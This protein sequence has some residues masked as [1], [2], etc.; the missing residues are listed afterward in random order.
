MAHVATRYPDFTDPIQNN[1]ALLV[2]V[3]QSL[4]KVFRAIA[5]KN[6]FSNNPT[7]VN[8]SVV[9]T[10]VSGLSFQVRAGRQY[11]IEAK[12]F[13]ST[14]VTPGIQVGTTLNGSTAA[15][16]NLIY[17]YYTT[18]AIAVQP[19]TSNVLS[20]AST[21]AA[22]AYTEVDIDGYFIPDVSG[23]LSVTFSQKVSDASNTTVGVGSWAS[24][25]RVRG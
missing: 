21:G 11:R 9:Q 17:K 12:L 25:L 3:K 14:G 8:T 10:P 24:V 16:G 7:T 4:N 20:T 6:V 18:A 15:T 2:S 13:T 1:G 23:L 19:V 22:V 5:G